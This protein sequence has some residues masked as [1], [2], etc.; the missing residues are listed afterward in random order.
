MKILNL[1]INRSLWKCKCIGIY[2]I[3]YIGQF[4]VDDFLENVNSENFLDYFTHQVLSQESHFSVIVIAGNTVYVAVDRVASYP[5]FYD[6]YSLYDT[7]SVSL[8]TDILDKHLREYF[9]SGFVLGENTLNKELKQLQAGG[10]LYT[11]KKKRI[12]TQTYYM[13]YPGV[14]SNE[15]SMDFSI[16]RLGHLVDKSVDRVIHYADGHCIILPL[17]GGLDSR[18]ILA[19]LVEKKYD[20]LYVFTYGVKN[21]HEAKMAR[22][23]CEKLNVNWHYLAFEDVNIDSESFKS[24]LKKYLD[25]CPLV[26]VI[27]SFLEI[28]GFYK[29]ASTREIDV[30]DVVVNGQTGD[31]VSGGHIR[32]DLIGDFNQANVFKYI[33]SKHFS[34][35]MDLKNTE[36]RKYIYESLN[37]AIKEVEHFIRDRVSII[38]FYEYWE[39]RERQSKLVVGG[40][41]LYESLGCKWALPLWDPNLTDFW[42]DCPVELKIGQK[43]YIDY[44]KAYNHKGVFDT[45][46]LPP[47][48]WVSE[49]KW[50]KYVAK[51]I[52][53]LGGRD[54]KKKYY[55]Y[56]DYYS[57]Y[58]DQ[59]RILGRDL[60]LS[61]WRNIRNPNSLIPIYSLKHKGLDVDLIQKRL[62]LK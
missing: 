35:R 62:I 56:M 25:H 45:L 24:F 10:L 26:S 20:N 46:R 41:R 13:Y 59:Y 29:L 1:F 53:L 36:T 42:R 12:C 28:L 49:Y 34:L 54:L 40:Q 27:P 9:M 6:E 30:T 11:N 16:E 48:P 17:S 33:Y 14:Y 23:V 44:L 38:S 21:S 15:G 57:T 52:G 22:H 43:L 2:K 39:W 50:I 31:F 32:P 61:C 7:Y 37:D 19:K 47:E 55:K 5:I 4:S 51:L 3:F 18:L 60:Y 58:S 8:S